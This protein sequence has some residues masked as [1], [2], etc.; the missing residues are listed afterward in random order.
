[1]RNRSIIALGLL[2]CI[3][4]AIGIAYALGILDR[5]NLLP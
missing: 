4:L 1:M 2:L 5:F 3:V